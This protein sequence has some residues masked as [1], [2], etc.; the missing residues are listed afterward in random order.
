MPIQL[1]SLRG[2]ALNFPQDPVSFKV[3]C[4]L[5]ANSHYL[6]VVERI[7]HSL[8]YKGS[9]IPSTFSDRLVRLIR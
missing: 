1:G 5:T 8:T 7:L 3:M 4:I 9:V 2:L 6:W